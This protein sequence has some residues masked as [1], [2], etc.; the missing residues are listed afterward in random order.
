MSDRITGTHR[1]MRPPPTGL[2]LTSRVTSPPVAGLAAS[3]ANT[4]C[5]VTSPVGSGPVASWWKTD[6]PII[7]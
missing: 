7:E 4:S 5:T 3:A 2:S 6:T 1:S